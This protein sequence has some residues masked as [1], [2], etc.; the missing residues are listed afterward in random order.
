MIALFGGANETPRY[1]RVRTPYIA[2]LSASSVGGWTAPFGPDCF[3]RCDA[4]TDS[5]C[6]LPD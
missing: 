5:R 6:Y 2:V 4:R 3:R 1:S